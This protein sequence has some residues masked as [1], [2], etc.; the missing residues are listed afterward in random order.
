LKTFT[1]FV[2]VV[3]LSVWTSSA[4]AAEWTPF[5]LSLVKPVQLFSEETKVEGLRLNLIYG[6]NKEVTGLDLGVV[7]EVTGTTK[8]VQAAYILGGN[9]SRDLDGAQIVYGFGGVNVTNGEA[10]GLQISGVGAG[11]NWAE[12]FNGVQ[13]SGVLGGIN[14]AA[15][16]TG[17]QI[18]VAFGGINM[19][20]NVTGFQIAGLLGGINKAANVRGVQIAGLAGGINWAKNVSGVQLSGVYGINIA[21]DVSGVQISSLYNQADAMEGLQLGLVN[22]CN[23]MKGAQVGL[24]NIITDS[25]VPFF[26]VINAHF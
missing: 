22:L 26:P 5:Q 7:N 14:K 3:L 20:E 23:K 6:V 8:G 25:N 21:K 18:T 16:M 17:L 10:N 1:K 12:E 19:A 4:Q 15:N 11:V 24:I 13:L 2:V 9:I